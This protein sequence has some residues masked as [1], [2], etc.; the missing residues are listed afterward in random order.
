MPLDGFDEI[1]LTCQVKTFSKKGE[2]LLKVSDFG[3]EAYR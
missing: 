2:A 3:F 1:S